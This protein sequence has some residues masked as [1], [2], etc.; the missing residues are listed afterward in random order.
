[1]FCPWHNSV[2]GNDKSE[3]HSMRPTLAF[4][5]I[6][7][8]GEMMVNILSDKILHLKQW[9]YLSIQQPLTHW[10]R[11]KMVVI[12]HTTFQMHFLEWKCIKIYQYF[13]EVCTKVS[14]NNIPGYKPFY[15]LMMVSLM[16][17]ICIN[18]SQWVNFCFR[19]KK[20]NERGMNWW[21]LMGWYTETGAN[22][23]PHKIYCLT[24]WGRD[25]MVAI[26]QT[27]FLSA[28]SWMEMFE[29]RLKFHWSLFLRV[30]LTKFQ[31]CFR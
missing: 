10:S 9:W 11:D 16:T 5:P 14:I 7:P 3:K 24:H 21:H 17:H 8:Y 25:K 27:T 13:V 22:Y 26:S 4:M 28:F 23:V 31:H 6:T 18:R 1:M 19:S 2:F 29:F 20:A 15:Q 12:F 30:Q